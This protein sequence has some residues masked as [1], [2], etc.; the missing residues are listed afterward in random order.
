V[1]EDTAIRPIRFAALFATTNTLV[2]QTMPL[3]TRLLITDMVGVVNATPTPLPLIAA[4][5]TVAG[6]TA[7][8]MNTDALAQNASYIWNANVVLDGGE[9][10]DLVT[11]VDCS[12]ATLIASGFY[13]GTS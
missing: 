11:T 10:L 9:S 8:A 13:W 3:G 2:S 5:I 12:F 4:F 7:F 1:I 6:N